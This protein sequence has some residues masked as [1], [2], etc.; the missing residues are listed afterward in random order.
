MS[1]DPDILFRDEKF[2]YRILGESNLRELRQLQTTCDDFSQLVLGR[3]SLPGDAQDL[4]CDLPPGKDISDKQVLGIYDKSEN[5]IGVLD[6]VR[7][8]PQKNICFIG[9]LMIRP[10]FRGKGAGRVILNSFTSHVQTQGFQA[11]MLAVVEENQSALRFW[12]ACGFE[13]FE[14]SPPRQFEEKTHCVIRMRKEL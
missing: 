1:N 10:E 13:I 4:L 7:H 8:Y 2:T 11:L 9:L 3:A 14:K 5:L 12:Q 6:A